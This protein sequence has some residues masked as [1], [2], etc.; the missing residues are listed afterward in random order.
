MLLFLSL[1]PLTLG[2]L[3]KNPVVTSFVDDDNGTWNNHV[4][5]GLW[6]DA[7]IIAPATAKTLSGMANGYCEN[8]L[9]ACYLSAKCPVF[10]APA[11]DLDMF[12]HPSTTE[13]IS[14]LVSIGN[15]LIP[16]GKGELASGLEGG[17]K[18][19]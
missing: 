13:N 4:E 14:K 17:R 7:M 15:T 11:M 9:L 1:H 6:A 2:T 12:K 19:G 16:A 8:L 18:N 5:L 3:S 10:F